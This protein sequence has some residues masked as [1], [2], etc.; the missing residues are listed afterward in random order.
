M[1]SR[2]FRVLT[3]S[4][5]FRCLHL[6]QVFGQKNRGL[7]RFHKEHMGRRGH[8]ES[9]CSIRS[10]WESFGL[11][12]SFHAAK[13]RNKKRIGP[14]HL[15]QLLSSHPTYTKYQPFTVW[16]FFQNHPSLKITSWP[17]LQPGWESPQ[18]AALQSDRHLDSGHVLSSQVSLFGLSPKPT[19]ILQATSNTNSSAKRSCCLTKHKSSTIKPT[20]V[21]IYII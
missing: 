19:N 13:W 7:K 2:W 18:I 14:C 12:P 5:N 20:Y 9:S 15:P 21:Y 11:S 6:H 3:R 17:C 8:Q 16:Y 4:W 10:W 1:I